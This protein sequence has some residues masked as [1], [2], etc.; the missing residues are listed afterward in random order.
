MSNNENPIRDQTNIQ[1][2]LFCGFLLE[3]DPPFRI[4]PSLLTKSSM[5][6]DKETLFGKNTLGN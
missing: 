4:P 5:L 3:R 1:Y 6:L 2:N